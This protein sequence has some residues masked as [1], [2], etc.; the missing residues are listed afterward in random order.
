MSAQAGGVAMEPPHGLCE[1]PV[2]T[3]SAIMTFWSVGHV[4]PDPVRTIVPLTE[5]SSELLSMKRFFWGMQF[6][7]SLSIQIPAPV[8]LVNE[9][10]VMLTFH[11]ATPMGFPVASKH[12][13]VG[14]V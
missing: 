14:P 7:C 8:S 12:P 2:L 1:A 5:L 10:L 11:W 3:L 13:D 6:A 9:F 4:D